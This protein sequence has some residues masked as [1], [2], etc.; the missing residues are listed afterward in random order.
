[1]KPRQKHLFLFILSVMLSKDVILEA[2]PDHGP[3]PDFVRVYSGNQATIRSIYILDSNCSY[4]LT[5]RIFAR[6]GSTWKKM[7]LPVAQNISLLSLTAKNIGWF[8]VNTEINT[9]DLYYFNQDRIEK[10]RSPFANEICAAFF[11]EKE[12][13]IFA[14]W[15][16]LAVYAKGQFVKIP[17]PPTLSAIIKVYGTNQKNIWL[18]N[19]AKELFHLKNNLYD[20]ILPHEQIKDFSF[21]EEEHGFVLCE[22]S[23]FEITGNQSK[24]IIEHDALL[25][26]NRLAI[27]DHNDLWLIGENGLILNV[28]DGMLK[29]T[30]M[31]LPADSSVISSDLIRFAWHPTTGI[32]S[33]YLKIYENG[34]KEIYSKL[35]ADT[36]ALIESSL[37]KPQNIYFWLVTTKQQP[38]DDEV[39]FTF[40]FGEKEWKTDFL[41]NEDQLMKE[42]ESEIN[43]ME[44]KMKK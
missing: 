1:M 6:T 28:H 44:K 3:V 26:A 35:L 16:E 34:V 8:T 11:P 10:I 31:I 9:S 42:L 19:G 20:R 2:H 23:I 21:S 12:L 4:F 38:T 18:L 30:D 15:G 33:K 32:P 24:K 25:N 5:D 17:P 37:L 39:R 22:S 14:G 7:D 27:I 29:K 13:G 41:D 43:A 40:V 36:T